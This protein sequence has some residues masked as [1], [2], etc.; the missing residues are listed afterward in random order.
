MNLVIVVASSCAVLFVLASCFLCNRR[1]CCGDRRE[2]VW[3]QRPA[4]TKADV[5]SRV[6]IDGNT[7]LVDGVSRAVRWSG[8]VLSDTGH[9]QSPRSLSRRDVVDR[10]IADVDDTVG[11]TV[12]LQWKHGEGSA[13]FENPACRDELVFEQLAAKIGLG[14]GASSLKSPPDQATIRLV[15]AQYFIDELASG[16]AMCPRHDLREDSF[17]DGP[18]DDPALQIIAISY[19]RAVDAE[20]SAEPTGMPRPYLCAIVALLKARQV[21]AP[22]QKLAVFLDVCSLD[23]RV[24]ATY[25]RGVANMPHIFAHP[26][27]EVWVVDGAIVGEDLNDDSARGWLALQKTLACTVLKKEN[28]CFDFGKLQLSSD[29]EV[30]WKSQVIQ[31][32]S[33]PRRAP[34]T[35]ERLSL[36][37]QSS[38]FSRKA[39]FDVALDLYR[40]FLT[41]SLGH[42]NKLNCHNLGWGDQEAV[43]LAEILPYAGRLQMLD[44]SSNPLIGDIGASALAAA[45]PAS[46]CVLDLR[47]TRRKPKLRC[48]SSWL[49]SEKA[50]VKFRATYVNLAF[51]SILPSSQDAPPAPKERVIGPNGLPVDDDED[52]EDGRSD[53]DNVTPFKEL[54]VAPATPFKEQQ[55]SETS[56][57]TRQA[58]TVEALPKSPSSRLLVEPT[59]RLVAAAA[60]EQVDLPPVVRGS[61]LDLR[62]V[63][64]PQNAG[65]ER[66]RLTSHRK[67]MQE[68]Q[69]RFQQQ[70]RSDV[71]TSSGAVQLQLKRVHSCQPAAMQEA[72]PLTLQRTPLSNRRAR[73]ARTSERMP[74]QYP[75][76]VL[77]GG[78]N[79]SMQVMREGDAGIAPP[80]PTATH[81]ESPMLTRRASEVDSP[82][83]MF[84]V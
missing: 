40:G 65:L 64:T 26:A 49:R 72:G 24:L 74:I 45:L 15:M 17:F 70:R 84:R 76:S 61:E 58:E 7:L 13:Y 1:R 75:S 51:A 16:D 21:Y 19:P 77:V 57:C 23:P 5:G 68:E 83:I 22:H 82:S 66:A 56:G 42:L 2:A 53:D 46:L 4:I 28:T 67:V 79:I 29:H 11:G 3:R 32:C 81:R 39:D 71:D 52:D 34:S 37:L 69:R 55:T 50:F 9:V 18:F 25:E 54:W 62:D 8:R 12:S 36:L 59:R 63:T 43:Q 47:A 20:G 60:A 73:P 33:V 44:L 78:V 14:G 31:Q 35:V 48:P 27:T 6:T 10:Q 38:K 80:F 30:H 41:D